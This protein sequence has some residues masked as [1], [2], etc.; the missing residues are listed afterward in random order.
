MKT[1]IG[2]K[3]RKEKITG[4]GGWLKA[5]PG[6]ALLIAAAVIG[7][8][9]YGVAT[10]PKAVDTPD[11]PV[12]EQPQEETKEP[13]KPVKE[14]VVAKT[15][16]EA[17]EEILSA[18]AES[19][20]FTAADEGMTLDVVLSA[21]A[22]EEDVAKVDGAVKA[23]LTDAA[24][25]EVNLFEK[26]DEKVAKAYTVN[27]MLGEVEG[28]E[29]AKA[30]YISTANYASNSSRNGGMMYVAKTAWSG[31]EAVE[32]EEETEDTPVASTTPGT[33]TPSATTPSTTTPNNTTGNQ[34]QATTPSTQTPAQTT[35]AQTVETLTG[36]NSSKAKQL[37]Q[38]T[39]KDVC[40]WLQ[41]PGTGINEPVTH[42]NDNQYYMTYNIYHQKEV[43]AGNQYW[44]KGA[45][46]ADYESNFN[47]GLPTNTIIYG[48]N[49]NNVVQPLADNNPNDKMFAEVHKYADAGFASSHPYI[50]FSTTERDYKFQV[51]AAFYTHQNWTDYIYA[52]PNAQKFANVIKTAKSK[53]LHNFG[54]NVSTSDKIISLSTCT[55]MMGA[56]AEYRF[57]VMGKLVG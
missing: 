2:E 50:Y 28:E 4:V 23:L 21:E 9:G 32:V 46:I 36:S 57:V 35:P 29:E 15:T 40:G 51:F 48:H 37:K 24:F 27:Y 3:S 47:N 5:Y 56:T 54:V 14:E 19:A 38:K 49:W 22:T 18:G 42:R 55:R 10:M 17:I 45:L 33:T 1:K 53:S 6:A 13:E 26:T 43:I 44:L 30:A 41:I 7:G 20:E 34:Q 11:V 25:V 8:V 39:N 52:Y 31:P 12:M 16:D